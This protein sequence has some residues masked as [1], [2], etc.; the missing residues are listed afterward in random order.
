M[1]LSQTIARPEIEATGPLVKDGSTARLKTHVSLKVEAV[2]ACALLFVLFAP[3]LLD[4]SAVQSIASIWANFWAKYVRAVSVQWLANPAFWSALAIVLI[5]ER[6]IPAR[7][8]QPIFSSGLRMDILWVSVHIALS[9]VLLPFCFASFRATAD[10]VSHF[11]PALSLDGA[12]VYVRFLAAFLMADFLAWLAHVVRHKI[13]LLWQ[14]HAVHHSQRQLNFFTE[15]RRHPVD[16]FIVYLRLLLP[17]LL[18][19]VPFEAFVGTY[20]LRRWYAHVTHS[21]IRANFGILRYVLVTPQSHRIHHSSDKRH[22]DTNF[23]ETLSIW[24][25]LFGTQH[26]NYDEYPDTGIDDRQFPEEREGAGILNGIR[27]V[28]AQLAYPFKVVLKSQ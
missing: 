20:W 27:T 2:A 23:G 1:P 4:G 9:V 10:S 14:F 24:D 5:L 25:H 13:S 19:N 15:S 12:P 8:Q 26:R 21:N 18:F 7:R 17:F 28:A 22:R 11:I 6:L 3:A 16:T